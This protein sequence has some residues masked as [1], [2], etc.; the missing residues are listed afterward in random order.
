MFSPLTCNFPYLFPCKDT[1]AV[2]LKVGN[3]FTR[4]SSGFNDAAWFSELST[5]TSLLDSQISG[6]AE[7]GGCP[8]TMS[9]VGSQGVWL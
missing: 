1:Q 9:T 8:V 5:Q 4:Q 3:M 6:A 2:K 7:A